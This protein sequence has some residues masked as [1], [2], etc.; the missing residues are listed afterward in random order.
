M[1]FRRFFSFAA[2]DVGCKWG[3]GELGRN[4]GLG[5]Y[6]SLVYLSYLFTCMFVYLAFSTTT[7]PFTSKVHVKASITISF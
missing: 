1:H 6:I 7:E 2:Y 4:F 3:I 5:L